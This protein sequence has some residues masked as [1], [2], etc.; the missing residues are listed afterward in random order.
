MIRTFSNDQLI[1]FEFDN[2]KSIQFCFVDG[3]AII[4]QQNN[5]NI[6]DK[7]MCVDSFVDYLHTIANSR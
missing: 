2:G 3:Y 1:R 5:L 7:K 4:Y 6:E